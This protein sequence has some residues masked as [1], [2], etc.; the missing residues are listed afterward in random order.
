MAINRTIPRFEDRFSSLSE[1]ILRLVE[2]YD[3][4]I[5]HSWES[6]E[7]QVVEFFHPSRM[8]QMEAMLPGWQK[9]TAYESGVTRTHVLC[10]FLGLYRMTEFKALDVHQQQMMKWVVLFHDLEK[11]V[12]N[13]K[14][15]HFHAFRS[16]VTAARLLP[17]MGFSTTHDYDQRLESWSVFTLSAFTTLAETGQSVQDNRKIPVILAGISQMFG[18]N[19]PAALILKTILFHLSVDM[20]EWP[21][22]NPLTQ[23]ETQR[24]FDRQLLPLLKVMHL[25]DTDGWTLFDPLAREKLYQDTIE[26]FDELAR[27]IT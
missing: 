2:F 6:L 16:A 7:K 15:D 21:P 19:T 8:E 18:D 27:V 22:A 25:A 3:T 17:G 26:V 24:Y 4:G 10:V 14:R 11:E 20:K 23:E 13:K 1:F 12:V 9:M 5:V